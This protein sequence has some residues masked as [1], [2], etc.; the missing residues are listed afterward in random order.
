MTFLDS[1]RSNRSG[2]QRATPA[3]R[4][5]DPA[6]PQAGE[7]FADYYR[8]S[9]NMAPVADAGRGARA[10]EN[11]STN[12]V[13]RIGEA[14][15]DV[16][17]FGLRHEFGRAVL[18]ENNR[19]SA[20]LLDIPM[21]QHLIRKN[22]VQLDPGQEPAVGYTLAND[23]IGLVRWNT[24]MRRSIQDIFGDVER[25]SGAP[26]GFLARLANKESRGNVNATPGTSSATGFFQV[27]D[28][29]WAS[30]AENPRF[31]ETYGIASMDQDEL[32]E[33]RGDARIDGAMAVEIARTNAE[34]LRRN[35]IQP[36]ERNLYM[37]HFGGPNGLNMARD[38]AQGGFKRQNGFEYFNEAER[39]ANSPIF[40]EPRR[41]ANNAVMYR[42]V[43][44][45]GQTVR[46]EIPN[47]SRPRSSQ[48]VWERLTDRFP[49][50]PV[51]F[52]QRSNGT[53]DPLAQ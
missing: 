25:V 31:R 2:P 11:A 4:R 47:Y 35:N 27:I 38:H 7:S 8:R 14:R 30:W 21:G 28:D 53:E 48:Q 5:P 16:V 10:V 50:T 49:D 52:G 37:G 51:T 40:W 1:T 15:R 20:R 6:Q 45:N 44:R 17:R 3:R 26:A 34:W 13:G 32:N 43:Q 39:N 23:S 9:P 24:D 29:T 33:Y 42:T 18:A 19:P 22:G 12:R 36:T 46:I 41:D